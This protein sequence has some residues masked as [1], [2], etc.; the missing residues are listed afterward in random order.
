MKNLTYLKTHPEFNNFAIFDI[1]LDRK[2]IRGI[3]FKGNFT[4]PHIIIQGRFFNESDF[5]N[6]EK[7]A[8]I[9]IDL[10][11][12]T[13]QYNSNRYI[14]IKEQNYKIIGIMG[15]EEK[16]MLDNYIFVNLDSYEDQNAKE[17]YIDSSNEMNIKRTLTNLNEIGNVDIILDKLNGINRLFKYN[18]V[19]NI[20]LLLFLSLAI[21]LFFAKYY[22]FTISIIPELRTYEII[23]FSKKE[24]Y[25]LIIRKTLISEFFILVIS[26]LIYSIIFFSLG[27]IHNYINPFPLNLLITILLLY[28]TSMVFQYFSIILMLLQITGMRSKK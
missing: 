26:I 13:F 14:K 20:I 18:Q 2:N 12:N 17:Y 6:N 27:N 1:S 16:T 7:K 8:V 21:V 19:N 9:G 3:F 5:L 4:S 23:G 24:I 28:I 11:N 15:Y 10:L 25:N 22:F